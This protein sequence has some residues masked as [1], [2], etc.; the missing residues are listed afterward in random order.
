MASTRN[1]YSICNIPCPLITLNL[2]EKVVA[3]A[4]L[5][6]NNGKCFLPPPPHK[7]HFGGKEVGNF[8]GRQYWGMY[9]SRLFTQEFKTNEKHKNSTTKNQ[10]INW[11]GRKR[12]TLYSVRVL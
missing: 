5:Q 9:S 8:S 1:N 2:R 3:S 12:E 10:V 6:H 7:R 11:F 4:F